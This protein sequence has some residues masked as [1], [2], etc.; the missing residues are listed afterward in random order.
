ME[1][2]AYHIKELE[3]YLVGDKPSVTC[4][5]GCILGKALAAIRSYKIIA[6]ML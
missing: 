1:V 4:I 5:A 3:L 2:P 6:N